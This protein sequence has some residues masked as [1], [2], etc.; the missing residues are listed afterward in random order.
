MTVAE[1]IEKL[2]AL[3]PDLQ[4]ILQ[5]DPEG[6][7]YDSLYSVD[8]D[9]IFDRGDVFS[10]EWTWKEAGFDSSEDW[11]E[12]KRSQPRCCVLAP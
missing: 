6:N 9:V 1:L 8:G 7:S 3:P 2:K 4:V 12:F 10:V 11:E 5:A